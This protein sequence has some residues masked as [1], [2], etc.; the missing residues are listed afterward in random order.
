ME[1]EGQ[2]TSCVITLQ[3]NEKIMEEERA[4][5]KRMHKHGF[6]AKY[7]FSDILHVGKTLDETIH[8]AE[9]F[10]AVE[11]NILIRGET[12]T[13]KEL[14]AQSIHNASRRKNKPFVAINC[15]ALP[16]NILESELFG[17]VEGAFTGAAKGGKV[18]FFEIAHKGTLFLDEIGDISPKLQS[19]LLR[20]LQEREIIRLGSDTVIPIDVRIIAATNKDLYAEVQAGAFREDLYY[21]LD[22]LELKLPPVRQRKQDIPCLAEH[23]L[24]FEREKHAC[25]LKGFTKGAMELLTSYDWPGNV[26]ELRNF[27]ERISILCKREYAEAAD[28]LRALP[29]LSAGLSSAPLPTSVP[30]N[31]REELQRI[32]LL[33]QGNRKETARYLGIH[34]STLWRKMKRLGLE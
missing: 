9:D 30:N 23:F 14:F 4:I 6:V 15:A 16:D 25:V 29:N 22:V 18:G 26:R 21:R 20:V 11:S 7:S 17:Y 5:R 8:N 19:R 3:T 34:P 24:N 28:V 27:C 12:G 32:L 13:G 1:V 2:V 10:S 33:H 31:E